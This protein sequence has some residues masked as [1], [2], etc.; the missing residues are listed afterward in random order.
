M[1]F[2]GLLHP[3]IL[4]RRRRRRRRERDDE[5]TFIFNLLICATG[6]SGG[7]EGC[8]FN[9]V[10]PRLPFPYLIAS[11]ID[12][13]AIQQLALVDNVIGDVRCLFKKITML[14]VDLLFV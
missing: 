6:I 8:R 7:G 9:L 4:K 13:H 10:L 14:G 1:Y 3:N 5:D 2:F 11:S 12:L